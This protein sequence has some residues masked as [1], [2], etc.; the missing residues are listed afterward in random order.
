MKKLILIAAPPASGKTY[1]AEKIAASLPGVVYLDKDDLGDLMRAAFRASGEGVDM[2]G[3]F[4]IENLRGAEY[5]TI[6]HIAFS[7]LRFSDCVILNAPFGKEV[8]DSEYMRA[9]RERANATGAELILIWVSTP[10]KT[11]FERMKARASDRD[12]K[13]LEEWE[14]Y[15]R[16]INYTPPTDLSR[17]GVDSFLLFDNS[18]EE[19]FESSLEQALNLIQNR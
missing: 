14:S 15:S 5:A 8:R 10:L 9:L 19:C 6:L 2:D 3:N 11:I 16:K 12:T 1:V 7:S 13:K 18:N 4:Y 17:G